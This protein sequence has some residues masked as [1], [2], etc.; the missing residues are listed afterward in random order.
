MTPHT[1]AY[2]TL[3]KNLGSRGKAP[4]VGPIGSP[5]LNEKKMGGVPTGWLGLTLRHDLFVGPAFG[6][7]GATWE[8]PATMERAELLP[9]DH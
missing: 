9:A 8:V 1:L 2:N 5:N 6:V 4:G 7:V 3:K